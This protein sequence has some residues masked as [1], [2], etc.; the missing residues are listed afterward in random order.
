MPPF[1]KNENNNNFD[2]VPDLEPITE[3]KKSEKDNYKLQIVWRN[4]ILM[5]A[6]HG[7]AILGVY[8]MFTKA[9]WQTNVAGRLSTFF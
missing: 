5:A 4:V 9:M 3:I 7:A 6:L 2:D 8:L 1:I